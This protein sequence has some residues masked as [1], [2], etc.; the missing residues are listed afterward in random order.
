M[1]TMFHRCNYNNSNTQN[2]RKN[3][4]RKVIWFSEPYSQNV[5][6]NIG[7]LFNKLVRKHFPESNKC[8][9]ILH[10]NQLKLSFCCTTN[11]ENM[12][13]LGKLRLVNYY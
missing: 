2:A 8:H 10:L 1:P 13:K 7:R 11:V 3:I 5:K 4:N 9:Q 6:S 12:I